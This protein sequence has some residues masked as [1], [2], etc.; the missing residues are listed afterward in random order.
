MHKGCKA[1]TDFP[2]NQI[3]KLDPAQ[4]TI[5]YRGTALDNLHKVLPKHQVIAEQEIM[6]YCCEHSGQCACDN[7]LV[8]FEIDKAL[9][10]NLKR[11]S[12]EH[13]QYEIAI[14]LN[15]IDIM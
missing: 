5:V 7:P 9:F 2:K 3:I 11:Q 6:N 8:I 13:E 14:F 4:F 15:Y 12:I 1:R 10:D